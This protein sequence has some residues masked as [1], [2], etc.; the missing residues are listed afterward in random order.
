LQA[1]CP[2]R[3]AYLRAA[4]ASASY[5]YEW[6]RNG[7]PLQ[8]ASPYALLTQQPGRYQLIVSDGSCR[9]TAS[10]QLRRAAAPQL[11]LPADT[12][13][14]LAGQSGRL[15][16]PVGLSSYRWTP[17]S[18]PGQV[19][20]T[21]PTFQPPEPGRYRLQA[22]GAAGCEASATVQVRNDC[23]PA[24][25]VP[26]AFS[27]N[28]DGRNERLRIRTGNLAQFELRIYNRWGQRVFFTTEPG[29]SWAGRANGTP[30]PEG[31][32]PY[33]LRY[34]R[35]GAEQAQTQRGT[36]TLLR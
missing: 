29:Q 4:E 26:S 3:A 23:P 24:V 20:A 15:E 7:Q 36:V 21:T 9:D 16:A 12:T 17:A 8:P 35:T 28:G 34:R 14:C 5:S 10:R 25:Q 31:V 27:P 1:L 30:L 32:Y 33:Q 18:A 6:L 11:N 22:S 19:L 2:D 13:L